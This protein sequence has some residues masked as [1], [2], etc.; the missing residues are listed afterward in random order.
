MAPPTI[1]RLPVAMRELT[2]VATAELTPLMRRITLA[3]DQLGAFQAAGATQ[4]AM[5]CY[6]P[7]DHVR[8]FFPDPQ[9]GIL[10][11]PRQ[12]EGRIHW[13][14]D[15]PAISRIYTPR[16]FDA[17][18]GELVLDFVMHGHGIA[19][20]WAAEAK[21]GDRIHLAGPKS[22]MQI[23]PAKRFLLLGDETALPAIA[24]WL[25][26]LPPETEVAAHVLITDPTARTA[27][28]PHPNSTVEWHDY[29]PADI[30][31]YRH[32]VTAVAAD[33]F[34]WGAGER[35]AMTDF[36]DHLTSMGHP[37]DMTDLTNYWTRGAADHH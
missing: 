5:Q 16:A 7:D 15:P 14:E 21:P 20:Q 26:M 18:S 19:G 24:N 1:L 22:S 25:E 33:C 27:L 30:Q 2:V 4:P 8:L 12:G 9:T 28:S 6:G 23:P 29:D 3:G 17:A 34:V 31:A 35:A 10:S 37:R 36:Q 13:P 32:L 11:L